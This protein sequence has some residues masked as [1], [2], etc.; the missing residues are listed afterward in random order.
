MNKI[1]ACGIPRS[2]STLVWLLLQKILDRQVIK[3]HPASW[4]P[5]PCE[6][7]VSSIRHPYD[8]AASCFRTRIV[9]KGDGSLENSQCTKQ[10]LTAELNMMNSNFEALKLWIQKYPGK[11]V[12]LRYEEFF[13]NF[14]VIFHMIKEQLGVDVPTSQRKALIQK[15]SFESNRKKSL[16][17][18]PGESIERMGT[19]HVAVGVPGSWKSI[20]PFWGYDLM[21]KWCD[22]ICKEWGYMK[23]ENQ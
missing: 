12:I 2:G 6:L 11:V 13:D 23:Y 20:I 19:S 7:I 4:S 15:Y 16:Q 1:V 10:G 17:I 3:A 8:T 14:N 9:G 5:E 22:P 18:N 21:K